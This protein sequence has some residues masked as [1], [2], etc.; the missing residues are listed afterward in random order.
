MELFFIGGAKSL[1]FFSTII[2]RKQTKKSSKSIIYGIINEFEKF[3]KILVKRKQTRNHPNQ[4]IYGIINE[5][6]RFRLNL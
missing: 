2:K 5:I 4:I 1:S 3:H 6:E